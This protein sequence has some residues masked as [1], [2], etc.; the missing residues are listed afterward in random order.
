[1]N[2]HKNKVKV[3]IQVQGNQLG[4]SFYSL[5]VVLVFGVKAI[6]NYN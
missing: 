5:G 3:H 1:M 2:K 6:K 4:Y